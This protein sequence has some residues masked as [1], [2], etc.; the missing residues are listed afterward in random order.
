MGDEAVGLWGTMRVIRSG[1]WVSALNSTGGATGAHEFTQTWGSWSSI[2]IANTSISKLPILEKEGNATVQQ[3][4]E[5][6]GQ[7]HF[8]RAWYYFEFLRRWGCPI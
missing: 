4:N 8:M 1:D 3:L 7:A 5:L 2:R 6:K